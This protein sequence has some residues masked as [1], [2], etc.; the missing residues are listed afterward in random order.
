MLRTV[1]GRPGWRRLLVSY[2]LAA[3]LRCQASSVV[4]VT[5]KTPVQRR[6]GMNRVS[7]VNQAR[8][9]G[10]Y[11]TRRAFRRRTAFSCRSTSSSA[12][13]AWSPRNIRTARPKVQRMSR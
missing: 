11:R 2:L 8:S 4:G 9:A 3:S 7:A 13:F 12:F 1:A 6:R 5:G 10:S